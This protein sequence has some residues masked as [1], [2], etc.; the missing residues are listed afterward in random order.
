MYK[1]TIYLKRD[2]EIIIRDFKELSYLSSGGSRVVLT[3]DFSKLNIHDSRTYN[4]KGA[5]QVSITGLEISY[6]ELN[7]VQEN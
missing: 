2:E 7:E 5:K 4:F 1:L 6:L 3:D